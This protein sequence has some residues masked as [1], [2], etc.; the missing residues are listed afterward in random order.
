MSSFYDAQSLTYLLI[1]EK[2]FLQVKYL[3]RKEKLI[4]TMEGELPSTNKLLNS[5]ASK[6]GIQEISLSSLAARSRCI[7][8]TM[9]CATTAQNPR[10]NTSKIP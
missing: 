6:Q 4:T 7:H 8:C 2:S 3:G 5:A 9:D 1:S 10:Q